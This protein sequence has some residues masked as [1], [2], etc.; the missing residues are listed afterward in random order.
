M[1]EPLN[2]HLH[3]RL[4]QEFGDVDVENAG[5]A[6]VG[7]SF[8]HS[9][10]FV[11]I[12]P[13][14]T[15]YVPCPFCPE[16][17]KKLS[18]NHTWGIPDENGNA[19]WDLAKCYSFD[20]L[21]NH[22]HRKVFIDRVYEHIGTYR[23]GHI[24]LR[25]G[26]LPDPPPA[27]APPQ[28][29]IVP[30]TA[31]PAAHPAIE[32]LCHRGYDPQHLSDHYRVGWIRGECPAN[33]QLAGRIYVPVWQHGVLVSWIACMV[34]PDRPRSVPR[35]LWP[36]TVPYDK[37]LYNLDVARTCSFGVLCLR[38]S[39][40]WAIGCNAVAA[41]GPVLT[42]SQMMQLK[43]LWPAL[44]VVGSGNFVDESEKLLSYFSSSL[45]IVRVRVPRL[46]AAGETSA[47]VWD[48]VC[49][50]ATRQGIDLPPIVDPAP[51]TT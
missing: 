39:D 50:A 8:S 49:A 41:L 16:P 44:F 45:N 34:D 13:G 48:A 21:G 42:Y 27:V 40:V 14:E 15:Y 25:P 24:Q 18:I 26:R 36:P 47:A 10:Q 32:Y 23:R 35:Y 37:L 38:P 33:P 1:L 20:C 2:P 3:G 6:Y 12:H 29:D 28:A 46:D 4:M 11:V 19:K 22:D 5:E 7:Y 9:S 17:S 51:G 43:R 30:L 31:L